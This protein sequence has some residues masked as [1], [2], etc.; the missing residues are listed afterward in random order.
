M[1]QQRR[2]NWAINIVRFDD[3][4]NEIIM[5]CSYF[6]TTL[7]NEIGLSIEG[8]TFIPIRPMLLRQH[9]PFFRV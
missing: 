1:F 2:S 3:N 7:L 5:P 9:N 8:I 4:V 6:H